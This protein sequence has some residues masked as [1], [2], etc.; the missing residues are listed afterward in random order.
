MSKTVGY[1]LTAALVVFAIAVPIIGPTAL[2]AWGF[3]AGTV[4]AIGAALSAAVIVNSLLMPKPKSSNNAQETTLQL[5][6]VAR[7]ALFGKSAT[8]GSLVDVFNYGGKYGTDHE[9]VIFALADHYCEDLVGVYVNDVFV[10]WVGDGNYAQFD[11]HHLSMYFRNGSEIQTLPSVVPTNGPGWTSDDT[12]AGICYAVVDYLADSPTAKHPAWPGGRPTF[13]W[14]VKGKRCY[15][16]RLDTTVGGSGSHRWQDPSTW[17]WSENPIVCH[18]NYERGVYACDRVDQPSMLLVGRGLTATEV[19][20]ANIFANANLCDEVMADTL[21]RYTTGGIV[22]ADEKFLDVAEKF[23]AACGGIIIQPEGSVEIE[24]AQA[25]TPSFAFTDDDLLVGSTVEWNE[26]IL[27]EADS[28]WLNTI[29]PRYVSPDQKWGDHAAPVRRVDA[30]LITDGGSREEDVVLQLVTV[31]RQASDVGEIHRKMGRLFGRGKVALPPRFAEIEEG[32]WGTWTSARRFGGDTKTFRVESYALD[33]KWQ[34]ALSL[35]EINSAVYDGVL[36]AGSSGGSAGTWDTTTPPID[37]GTPDS[38]NWALAPV[39]LTDAGVSTGALELTGDSTDDGSAQAIIVETW[40]D[41][42]V[43]GID[44]VANPDD[45]PW[46]VFGSFPP[47]AT[48]ID[49]TG[50]VGGTAYY[51]AVTYVVSGIYGDRLVLGPQTVPTTD[52]SGAVNPLIDAKTSLLSWK[53]PVR[54]KTTAALAANTYANG[55]SGVGATLTGNSN[56]A[57]AAQDGVTLVAANRLLVANEA[58]GSHNGIYVVTQVGD[59]SHP[60]ILTRA[61]DADAPAELVNA[62]V[63]VS[64]G[65]VAAD[66]E[67]QCTTNATI[68]VGTTALVWARFPDIQSLLDVIGSTRGDVLY[69][70][71]SAWAR[72]AAGSSGNFLKTQGAG[73]DP[74]WAQVAGVGGGGGGAGLRFAVKTSGNYLPADT[75][76]FTTTT[77][78]AGTGTVSFF[79]FSKSCTINALAIEVTTAAAGGNTARAALYTANATTGLPDV[80]IEEATAQS[81]AST[82]TKVFPFAS[83]HTITDLVW[84]AIQLSATA[85]VRNADT[86]DSAIQILGASAIS[87]SSINNRITASFT[88]GAFP[89]DT[90]L[91][92]LGASQGGIALAARIA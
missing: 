28:E 55:S 52:V 42:G 5:G 78:S 92:T 61:T 41:D 4:A 80:L 60:Y 1:V 49:I 10:P 76:S 63:K 46:T 74:V 59:G 48:K 24:P 30:D 26:G 23:A 32:D 36:A 69:R 58:T 50:L 71:T 64:E 17:E 86:A 29:V 79:P 15:D 53:S 82:G 33:G 34:N 25:R 62:T 18:Y 39:T 83:S 85:T 8:A 19:P 73:A 89:A 45:P 21:A 7:R 9:V 87:T 54:A 3:S 11:T 22:A 43:G 40:P 38:G 81:I 14:V 20:P 91:L 35:R 88:F 75:H 70:G 13:L 72:L 47:S 27:S 6:E 12:G 84:I 67:W 57:L 16:P 37:I 31:E 44:P 90:S 65:T 56:G 68:A 66:Q 51:V 2:A 77:V